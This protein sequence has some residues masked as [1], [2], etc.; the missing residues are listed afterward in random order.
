[1]GQTPVRDDLYRRCSETRATSRA[2][3]ARATRLTEE[4]AAACTLAV[5][6][7]LDAIGLREWAAQIRR[8][9]G[10]SAFVLRG[11]V[12]GAEAEA[13][14]EHGRLRCPDE[15][16][17]RAE[18]MVAM[19][20]TF[21]DADTGTLAASLEGPPDAVLLTVMRAFSRVLVLEVAAGRPIAR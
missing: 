9:V 3:K 6:L 1:M 12:D 7:R 8:E 18:V 5:R 15:V 10:I 16:L 2:N 20:E 19:G 11:L 4:A 17:R 14:F 13:C 21:G